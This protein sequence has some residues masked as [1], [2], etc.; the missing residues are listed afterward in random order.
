MFNCGYYQEIVDGVCCVSQ[1]KG[2]AVFLVC[3]EALAVMK[4]AN[5]ERHY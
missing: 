2:K 1:I 5:L 4:K 3:C